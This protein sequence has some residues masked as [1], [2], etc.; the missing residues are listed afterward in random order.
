MAINN[1]QA[2]YA[3]IIIIITDATYTVV[4]GLV[5]GGPVEPSRAGANARL[6]IA[7]AVIG[8]LNVR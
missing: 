8:T 7:G 6:F 3:Y 4:C 2:I 1:I 5:A